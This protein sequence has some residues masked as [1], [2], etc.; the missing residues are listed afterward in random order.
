MTYATKTFTAYG[1]EFV[2]L[3]D[4]NAAKRRRLSGAWLRDGFIDDL[5]APVCHVL[6]TEDGRVFDDT[7]ADTTAPYPYYEITAER[8]GDGDLIGD[9]AA[10]DG[11]FER[12][13]ISPKLCGLA[14]A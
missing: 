3:V 10:N 5:R 2:C 6:V 1:N 11:E 9:F 12:C 14:T 8:W 7:P 4:P 13:G